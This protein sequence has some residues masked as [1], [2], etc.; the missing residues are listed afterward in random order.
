[1]KLFKKLFYI[2]SISLF[3]TFIIYYSVRAI[4]YKIEDGKKTN[5]SSILYKR[6]LQQEDD[7]TFVSELEK[8]NDNYYYTKKSKYNYVIYKGLTWRIIKFNKKDITMILETPI[9]NLP[10]DKVDNWLNY[11]GKKDSGIFYKLINTEFNV[12]KSNHNDIIVHNFIHNNKEYCEN[13]IEKISLLDIDDY[14]NVGGENSYLNK[15]VDFWIKGNKEYKY[16]DVTGE[17]E[18]GDKTSF[19]NVRPVITINSTIKASSGNGSIDN[20]YYINT[21]RINSTKNISNSS[22][23]KYNGK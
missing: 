19:H 7:Y 6:I 14:N 16:I 1:M 4:Y 21:K 2:F 9:T 13:I 23:L 8:I 18:T 12:D 20:P 15:K 17:I 11:Y 10:L 3:S 5:Y 22:Y